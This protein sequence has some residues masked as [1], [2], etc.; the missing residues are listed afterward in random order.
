ID[1]DG[2][3]YQS[4][5][6]K[7]SDN[8]YYWFLKFHHVIADGFSFSLM[9]N[10]LCA[11]Y[12]KRI[13]NNLP[14]EVIHSYFPEYVAGEQ[15][16]RNSEMY[17]KDRQF[18]LEM[19][20]KES[21]P[22]MLKEGNENNSLLS[23]RKEVIFKRSDFQKIELFCKLHEV[24]VF[25]YFISALYIFFSGIFLSTDFIVGI[26]VLNRS[27]KKAKKFVG[28]YFNVF[29]LHL[30]YNNA[31]TIG[32]LIK[33]VKTDLI[34]C[35]KHMRFPILDAIEAINHKGN[36][37]NTTFSY[38]KIFYNSQ[39][40][41]SPADIVYMKGLEQ[42]DDL[43]IHILDFNDAWDLKIIFDHKTVF[44]SDEEA[45]LL[46]L[47]FKKLLLSLIDNQSQRIFEIDVLREDGEQISELG[48]FSF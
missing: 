18:W 31:L 8:R 26:P 33:L 46:L 35:I 39:L 12:S 14:V 15:E 7:H 20:K 22:L 23:R 5:L 1:L 24:T 21:H 32:E 29:P 25:H 10:D 3:L 40:G 47:K 13:K 19:I 9:F 45:E 6:L 16:Y 11:E 34:S 30:S 38:Q 48:N 43:D 2:R 44:F 4:A 27:G 42:M 28:P 36:L 41:E 37:Y 17:A